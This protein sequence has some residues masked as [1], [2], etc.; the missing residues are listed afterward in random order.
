MI[1][2]HTILGSDCG[3]QLDLTRAI[4]MQASRTDLQAEIERLRRENAELKVRVQELSAECE[5]FFFC[6]ANGVRYEDKLP[7]R[8]HRRDRR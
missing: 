1:C 6:A 2:V 4:W 7:A 8:R 3:H 5:D